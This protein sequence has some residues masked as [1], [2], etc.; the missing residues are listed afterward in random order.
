[1]YTGITGKVGSHGHSQFNIIAF[2]SEFMTSC[3][4]VKVL[5][6]SINET[7]QAELIPYKL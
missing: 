5:Q 4:L 1:M 6:K 3:Y 7:T 2:Q